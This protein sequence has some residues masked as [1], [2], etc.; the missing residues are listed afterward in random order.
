MENLLSAFCFLFLPSAFCQMTNDNL[1]MRYGKSA[2][3]LL[4]TAYCLL[5]TAFCFLPSAGVLPTSG[6]ARLLE[7]A[8]G[9]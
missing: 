1:D 7:S 6:R 4:L 2:Y 3:C 8:H 5:L 9:C